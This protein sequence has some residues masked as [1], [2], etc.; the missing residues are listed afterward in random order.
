MINPIFMMLP[1]MNNHQKDIL[2]SLSTLFYRCILYVCSYGKRDYKDFFRLSLNEEV[3]IFLNLTENTFFSLSRKFCYIPPHSTREYNTKRNSLIAEE[4]EVYWK[5][6]LVYSR[7][8]II[9]SLENIQ[10]QVTLQLRR[11]VDK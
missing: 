7:S 10:F 2:Y 3:I 5:S 9:A 4:M 1:F 8:Y 6:R 11:I